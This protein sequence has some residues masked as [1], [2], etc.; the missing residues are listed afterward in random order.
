MYEDDDAVFASHKKWLY[1]V[2]MRFKPYK[3]FFKNTHNQTITI[4]YSSVEEI[5][6]VASE[7]SVN[8]IF[9]LRHAPHFAAEDP[10]TFLA[11]LSLNTNA[12]KENTKEIRTSFLDREYEQLIAGCLVY[13]FEIYAVMVS[14]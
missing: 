14:K 5:V 4:A 3:L 10:L 2:E 9:T 11:Q 1:G 7:S 12:R 6:A 13:R 8:M